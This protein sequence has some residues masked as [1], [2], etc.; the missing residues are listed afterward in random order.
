M[1]MLIFVLDLHKIKEFLIFCQWE[2]WT[3]WFV[4]VVGTE[5]LHCFHVQFVDDTIFFC[6][7]RSSFINLNGLLSFFEAIYGRNVNRESS[8]IGLNCK[9][10]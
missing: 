4:L 9:V 7:G 10:S 6:Y 5:R 1:G 2:T 8:N 3:F